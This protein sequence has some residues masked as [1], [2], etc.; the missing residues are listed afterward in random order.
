MPKLVK[1]ETDANVSNYTP[2]AGN[3]TT[4]F[5]EEDGAVKL[6]YKNSAGE[7]AELSGGGGGGGAFD[8]VKVT[9]YTPYQA[10]FSGVSKVT[11]SGFG[12]D[13]MSG[14]DYSEFNGDWT[15]ENPDEPDP[16][17][18]TFKR[19]DRYLYFFPDPEYRVGGD[20]WCINRDKQYGGYETELYYNSTSELTNGTINWSSM[21]GGATT[22]C[23]VTKANYPE[24]QFVLKGQ[25]ATAYDLA[26][27]VWTFDDG[28]K[29]F[30]GTE[31]SVSVDYI[32]GSTQD[33]IIGDKVAF[34]G[35]ILSLGLLFHNPFT[36]KVSVAETGQTLEYS[37]TQTYTTFGGIQCMKIDSGYVKTSENSG[38]TG[39]QSRTFS[40]WA[41]PTVEGTYVNAVGCG[42][43]SNHGC[44]FNCGVRKDGSRLK[45]QFTT[46]GNDIDYDACSADNKMHHFV[47]I[48]SSSD[49]L[50][51][52][53]DGVLKN[54]FD[55]SGINT[56]ASPFFFGQSGAGSWNYTG[57]LAEVRCYDRV[58]N[59]DEVASLYDLNK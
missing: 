15:V 14:M 13:D 4:F 18:R 52:Y 19:N 1:L 31:K 43:E 57:Y 20:A 8:L 40:F 51:L 16:L 28:I 47:Y 6:K 24:V 27:K 38:I 46:W 25:K 54:T 58:L 36:S 2:S 41:Y 30:V 45:A 12:Y 11:F 59:A 10:P 50:Q 56:K 33:V 7:I 53:V 26:S 29:S 32:Y 22:Q 3:I 49:K 39:T 37:G 48:L 9:E 21:G 35:D 5:A 44:M 34:G 55:V 23:T 42:N 17:K